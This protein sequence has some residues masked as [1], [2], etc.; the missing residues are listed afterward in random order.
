VSIE[1][2]II[3]ILYVQ[4]NA[5]KKETKNK[6]PISAT[7]CQKILLYEMECHRACK[8]IGVSVPSCDISSFVLGYDVLFLA[9]YVSDIVY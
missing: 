6:I 7:T 2:S 4:N 8:K 5:F 3:F 9:F 1:M